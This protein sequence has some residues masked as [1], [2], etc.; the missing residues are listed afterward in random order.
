[1]QEKKKLPKNEK[2]IIYI[3]IYI[4]R[5]REREREREPFMCGKTMYRMKWRIV[6]SQ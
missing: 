5:E 4:E 2:K 3:Y 6:N 1:M